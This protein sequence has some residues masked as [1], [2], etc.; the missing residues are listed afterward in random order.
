MGKE[1][2]TIAEL[3]RLFYVLSCD[4]NHA[5]LSAGSDLLPHGSLLG[6]VHAVCWCVE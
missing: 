6:Y 3:L 1:T 2:D 4:N 5:A